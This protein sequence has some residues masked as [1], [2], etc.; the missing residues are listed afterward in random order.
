MLDCE[1]ELL[2]GQ[3]ENARKKAEAALVPLQK[4]RSASEVCDPVAASSEGFEMVERCVCV[5]A[6]AMHEEGK[7]REALKFIA[8][9]YGDDIDGNATSV[10]PSP[11]TVEKIR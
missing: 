10:I 6:Q 11:I 5:V 9:W 1:T 8:S 4:L 3:W 2:A 7:A